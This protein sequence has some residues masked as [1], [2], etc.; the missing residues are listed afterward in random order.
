VPFIIYQIRILISSRRTG[1]DKMVSSTGLTRKQRTEERS[2]KN[3]ERRAAFWKPYDGDNF[4]R[5]KHVAN[6]KKA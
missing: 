6:E 4:G 2:K 3:D 5:G 1:G